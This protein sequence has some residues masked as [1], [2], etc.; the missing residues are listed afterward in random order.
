M[1]SAKTVWYTLLQLEE[2]EIH[3]NTPL[4]FYKADVNLKTPHTIH[5]VKG[6]HES[7]ILARSRKGKS[8]RK[9]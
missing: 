7:L 9:Q 3:W 5:T 2:G 8:V 1:N 6:Y 4:L